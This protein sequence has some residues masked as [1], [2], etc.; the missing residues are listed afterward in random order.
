MLITLRQSKAANFEKIYFENYS[1]LCRS[2]YRFVKDE[3]IT[4]DIV[5]EVFLKLWQKHDN[6]NL[7]DST[8]SYIHK[9]CINQALNYLKEKERRDHR[10]ETFGRSIGKSDQRSANPDLKY[11]TSETATIINQSID[12]L[13]TMCKSAFLLSRYEGKSYKEIAIIMKISIN[14]V[15]KHIGKALNFLRKSLNSD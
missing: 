14:T 12:N 11:E 8:T 3:E 9:A 1:W 10:E 4:K 15:E 7:I 13:P 5:Q 6:M 2:V